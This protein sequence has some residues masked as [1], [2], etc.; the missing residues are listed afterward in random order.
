G[1]DNDDADIFAEQFEFCQKAQIPII[2]NSTLNVTPGT[3]L[4]RRLRAEGRLLL[5]DWADD[6]FS[7]QI[8][9]GFTNFRPL[10]M[11][12]EELASGQQKLIRK[13]Y[14]TEAF[15]GRLLGNLKRFRDVRFRPESLT[16]D[17]VISSGRLTAFYWRQGRQELAFFLR[18]LWSTLR[19]CRR[20]LM[21]T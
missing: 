18:A 12:A 11:T 13:L 17:E 15:Q 4:A 6:D 19:H 5:N 3:P 2:M 8:K 1:F 9:P 14:E 20:K 21:T 10:R 16:W 7:H